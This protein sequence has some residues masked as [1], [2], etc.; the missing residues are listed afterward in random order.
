MPGLKVLS[1][2]TF[3]LKASASFLQLRG[4]SFSQSRLNGVDGLLQARVVVEDVLDVDHGDAVMADRRRGAA[5]RR[6]L[7]WLRCWACRFATANAASNRATVVAA[8]RVILTFE[9]SLL[10]TAGLP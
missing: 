10:V 9:R 8:I 7:R 6:T 4:R 5:R 1:F 2:S 3:L